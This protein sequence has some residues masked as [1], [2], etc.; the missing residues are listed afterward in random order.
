MTRIGM[1]NS[2]TTAHTYIELVA[3]RGAYHNTYMWAI[4]Y[5]LFIQ[6][7]VIQKPHPLH[8]ETQP[9]LPN[10]SACNIEN[11]GKAWVRGYRHLHVVGLVCTMYMYIPY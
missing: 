6:M 11:N 3:G 10:F 5:E 7:C 9:G 4:A 8:H 2:Y 1:N